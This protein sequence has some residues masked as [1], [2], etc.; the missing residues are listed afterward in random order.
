LAQMESAVFG[1]QDLGQSQ[2]QALAQDIAARSTEIET[3]VQQTRRIV[4]AAL[5]GDAET[6][7][8]LL[9]ENPRLAQTVND[10]LLP[11]MMATLY[12]GHEEIAGMLAA[13]CEELEICAAAAL[14]QLDKVEDIVRQ[15]PGDINEISRDGFTPLQLACYFGRETTALWLIEHDADVEA[16]AQNE[17]RIRPIHAAASNGNLVVLRALLQRGA[18]VNARQQHDFTPLHT[19]ADRGDGE[20]ARL[21]LAHG[22]DVQARDASGRTAAQLAQERGHDALAALLS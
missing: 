8:Q 20:M 21:F 14:G 17:Q 22:A 12:R 18:N 10:N 16:V 11:L 5:A 1:V 3:V 9:Q 2:C 4:Q 19:A 15:W 6:V 13:A 7:R